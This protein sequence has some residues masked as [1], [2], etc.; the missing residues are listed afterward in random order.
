MATFNGAPFLAEQLLSLKTQT[1][2]PQ[3]LVISDD[4][5]SDATVDIAKRF[6]ARAPFDVR[7]ERN[8]VRL[9]HPKNFFKAASLCGGDLVAFC[10]QD[11]VWCK[12]KLKAS[13][14]VFECP[15]S[16][17]VA[18]HS[19][20]VV[21]AELRPLGYDF[22]SNP[23][24]TRVVAS[25]CIPFR[26]WGVGLALTFRR[27]LLSL[28][29]LD[30]FDEVDRVHGEVGHDHWVCFLAAMDRGLFFQR[31]S[32]ALYR[33]HGTNTFGARPNHRTRTMRTVVSDAAKTGG[34]H[35]LQRASAIEVWANVIAQ[36]RERG[37]LCADETLAL[38]WE[39]PPPAS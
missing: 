34:A 26:Y 24:N 25:D 21:D 22:P 13:V 31:D 17:S 38:R 20:Q 9:G 33:Q 32:L 18:V 30:L 28:M 23:A 6:A 3:E 10:D 37:A 36:A 15:D 2:L 12:N 39:D 5:S 7:I 14:A 4:G 8:S 19:A 11:D 27:P 16:P 35:Y 1:R 29:P